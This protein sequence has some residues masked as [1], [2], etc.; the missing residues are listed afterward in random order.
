MLDG[1]SSRKV[2]VVDGAREFSDRTLLRRSRDID[3]QYAIGSRGILSEG[4]QF[5]TNI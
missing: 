1:K 4:I 3:H 5:W 2:E